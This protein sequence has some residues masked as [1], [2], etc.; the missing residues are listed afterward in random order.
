[1]KVKKNKVAPPFGECEF[2]IMFNSSIHSG[3]V[4]DLAVEYALVDKRGAYS[5]YGETFWGKGAKTPK[6]F[7]KKTP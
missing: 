3:D 1:M 6:H 2:D 4:L 7:W 5:R